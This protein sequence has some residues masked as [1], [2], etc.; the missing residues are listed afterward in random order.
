MQAAYDFT[1][2]HG[3]PLEVAHANR[4]EAVLFEEASDGLTFHIF[5]QKEFNLMNYY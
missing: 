1:S 4:R 5:M 3:G 2:L